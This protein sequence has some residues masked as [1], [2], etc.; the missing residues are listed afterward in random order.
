M[1]AI[2]TSNRCYNPLCII[3]TGNYL[4]HEMIGIQT[5][6]LY[7]QLNIG[8]L[9]LNGG[10]VIPATKNGVLK[11]PEAGCFGSAITTICRNIQQY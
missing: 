5:M 1:S 3:P 4:E 10:F 9:L 2:S 11:F 8:T 7:V 6:K